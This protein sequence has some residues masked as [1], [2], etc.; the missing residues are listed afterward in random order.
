VERQD[1]AEIHKDLLDKCLQGDRKAHYKV[2]QLYS[3]A[4]FNTCLRIVNKVEEAEDVLQESFLSAFRNLKNFKGESS[5]GA[6][7]KKIVINRSLNHLKKQKIHFQSLEE[8]YEEPFTQVN[9]EIEK[10]SFE[11]ERIRRTIPKLPDGFRLVFSLYLIEGYDHKEIASIMGITESTSKS[12]YN[13]AKKKLR[14]L[15]LEA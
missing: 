3:K 15:L 6:W 10:S 12:Q 14:Q 7:L 5:F 2:Y 1:Y 13:R 11:I 8:I 4:M 9:D